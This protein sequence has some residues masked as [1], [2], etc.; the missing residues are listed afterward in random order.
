[1]SQSV[2]LID[3][4]KEN[5]CKF[6]SMKK[7][8]ERPNTNK[9]EERPKVYVRTFLRKCGLFPMELNARRLDTGL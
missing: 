2:V 9:T 8:D 1:M 7:V 4:N 3:K 5:Q 6:H